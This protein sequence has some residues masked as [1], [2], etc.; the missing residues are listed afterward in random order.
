VFGEEFIE[1]FAPGGG[2]AFA[3]A[4]VELVFDGLERCGG[5]GAE[6]GALGRYWRSRA[7]SV[8]K[9]TS[10]LPAWTARVPG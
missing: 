1:F 6:V 10:A 3:G 9:L 4:V 5:P 2:V 7:V 8:D